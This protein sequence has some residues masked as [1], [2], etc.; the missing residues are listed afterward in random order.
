MG[1][2]PLLALGLGDVLEDGTVRVASHEVGRPGHGRARRPF[3]QRPPREVAAEDDQVGLGLF[4]FGEDGLESGC[5]PVDVREN[6]DALQ[7]RT[8][9]RLNVALRRVPRGSA[10]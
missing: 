9:T 6:G 5:V 4:D 8:R 7:R 2:H 3:R 1:L 10:E